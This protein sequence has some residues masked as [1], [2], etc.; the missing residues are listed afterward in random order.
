MGNR[1]EMTEERRHP[2][3][4]GSSS[5]VRGCKDAPLKGM[6]GSLFPTMIF[7]IK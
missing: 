3:E 7:Q 2:S 6:A 5:V 1:I 4:S